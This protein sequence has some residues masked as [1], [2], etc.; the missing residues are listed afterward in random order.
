MNLANNIVYII[1]VTLLV[2]CVFIGVRYFNLWI[3]NMRLNASKFMLLAGLI[4]IIS[5]RVYV[6]SVDII[7]SDSESFIRFG[8]DGVMK[9]DVYK[10]WV[11]GVHV[12]V[13]L[14]G[15]IILLAALISTRNPDKRDSS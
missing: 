4:A 3:K 15:M 2:V 8:H 11:E 1:Y 14:A 9:Y 6:D 13:T 5:A 10:V 7:L 12:V